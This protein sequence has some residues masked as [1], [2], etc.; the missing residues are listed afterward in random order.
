MNVPGYENGTTTATGAP[1]PSEWPSRIEVAPEAA[2]ASE[3]AVANQRGAQWAARLLRGVGQ[4]G[5]YLVPLRLFIGLGWLR[6]GAEKVIDPGWRDGTSLAAFLSG[7]VSAGEV[8]FPWY[9]TLIAQVFLPH[10]AALALV[11]MLGQF[12]A[13][14]A[15]AAGGL[16]NAAL[17]GGLFMNLNFLL[18]GAPN[19]STFYI[20]IQI[21]LLLTNAGAI[22]G[23]DAGLARIIH[24]PLLVAQPI[25]ER[26]RRRWRVPVLPIGAISLITA[27][28]A[29]AHVTDWSPAGSVEDPAMVVA[30]LALLSLSWATIAWL[31]H[32]TKGRGGLGRRDILSRPRQELD[33]RG[34]AGVPRLRQS[35]AAVTEWMRAADNT[36]R[37]SR[38][39]QWSRRLA[40]T[41]SLTWSDDDDRGEPHRDQRAD[42]TPRTVLRTADRR[43]PAGT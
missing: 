12:L 31:S 22:L 40:L 13:G 14:V 32:E 33:F 41:V 4:D 38:S 36:A 34:V 29:L 39:P 24:N 26:R 23:L 42:A 43:I 25:A 11:I 28:Y 10:A 21:A 35:G 3:P 16:T 15:I 30:I 8:A 5:A 6:A 17:L 2:P 37:W 27:I 20:V 18:A 7:H 9:E 1:A 19:P